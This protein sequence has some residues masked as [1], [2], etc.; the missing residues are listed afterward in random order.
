MTPNEAPRLFDL[1]LCERLFHGTSEP[2][3]GPLRPGGYD[4]VFWTAESSTVAQCYIPATGGATYASISR[5]QLDDSVRPTSRSPF[6]TVAK[7]I[8]PAAEDIELDQHGDPKSWRLPKGYA[9]YR[10]VVD[11]IERVLGYANR[12]QMAGDHQY[13]LRTI[14]WDKDAQEHIIVPADYRIQG[15]LVMVEGFRGMRIADLS[16]GESD[17]TDLQYHRLKTFRQLESEGFDGVVIDDFCQSRTWGNVGHRS[18]GF[19]EHAITRLSTAVIPAQR[20]DWDDGSVG[21]LSVKDTPEYTAWQ[22]AQRA[23]ASIEAGAPRRDLALTP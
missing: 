5:Y 14:G 1:S 7:M 2:L 8:G 11:H 6:Y 19:F 22:R 18:I 16:R 20:F 12:S 10:Q 9:T 21:D 13:E 4:G 23:L 15:S 17:L 3:E